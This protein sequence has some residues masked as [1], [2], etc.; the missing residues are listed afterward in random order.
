[1]LL[2]Q[3]DFTGWVQPGEGQDTWGSWVPGGGFVPS[4]CR[5]QAMDS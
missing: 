1:M 2:E 5:P 4:D 3:W